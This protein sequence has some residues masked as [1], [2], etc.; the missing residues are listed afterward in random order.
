MTPQVV[1][2]RETLATLFLAHYLDPASAERSPD[3]FSSCVCGEWSEGEMEPGWDDHLA[4]VAVDAGFH[5]TPTPQVVETDSELRDFIASFNGDEAG[6]L[7]DVGAID[8]S[9]GYVMRG[10]NDVEAVF[11]KAKAVLSPHV[12]DTTPHG[13]VTRWRNDGGQ[14]HEGSKCKCGDRWP[15]PTPDADVLAEVRARAE[16]TICVHKSRDEYTFA[17]GLVREAEGMLAILDRE[18]TQ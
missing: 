12:V 16:W 2:E 13:P 14:W 3:N 10:G 9:M 8:G 6:D 7:D 5:M 1:D 15:H 17:A 18:A 4:D 11:A